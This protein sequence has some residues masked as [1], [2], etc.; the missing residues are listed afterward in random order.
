VTPGAECAAEVLGSHPR[1]LVRQTPDGD[2]KVNGV[3]D[4]IVALSDSTFD[5]TIS[6]SEK[7]VLVDFWAEWCGPCKMI[8]PV[9]EEIASENADKI[10]IVKLNVDE[11]PNTAMRYNVMSIPT[12]L[13]F[14]AGESSQEA[15]RLVGAK[16]K[17]Q[18]LQELAEF[19]G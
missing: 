3:G 19:V 15:R 14:K 11:N 13:V 6:G 12:L 8:G 5:E 18:L 17:A 1:R 2:R 9:L 4:H 7:P 16:G 10:Q